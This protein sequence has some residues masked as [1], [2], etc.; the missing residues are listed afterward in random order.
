[1]HGRKVSLEKLNEIAFEVDQFAAGLP[2][3]ADN[4]TC[5]YGG[6]VWFQKNMHGGPN[7][8]IP[9]K[10]EIPHR[11]E[12]FVLI[13]TGKPEKTTGELV[14]MVR[15]LDPSFRE[16]RMKR[17]GELSHQ[18][19]TALKAKD[20]PEIKRIMNENWK[21]LRDFGL[22]TL[23]ADNLIGKIKAIGGSAKLCGACGGG[24]LLACHEDT[25][26]LKATIKSAG[27][28]PMEVELGVEGV[29]IER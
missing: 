26:R 14:Q 2:S 7:T 23:V 5:C 22:S 1:V 11:L 3:G 16:P 9:L 18:M 13:Y 25:E 19:R 12:N 29:R 21:L 17:I 6:L 4:T 15:M 10:K 27:F 24:M 20:Y 8:I 28:E